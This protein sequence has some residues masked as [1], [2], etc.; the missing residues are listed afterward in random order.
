MNTAELTAM[1][2][3]VRMPASLDRLVRSRPIPAPAR[4]ERMI[5][6]RNSRLSN[7]VSPLSGIKVVRPCSI[8]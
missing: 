1:M 6:M 8:P 5:R 4:Q 2:Q 7:I 3:W